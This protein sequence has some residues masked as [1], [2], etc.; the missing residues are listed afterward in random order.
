MNNPLVS[1]VVPS[2]NH[3]GFISK[4]IDSVIKQTYINWELIIVDNHSTDS[5][6]SNIKKFHD[7]RIRVVKIQNN[8]I[9][10]ISRNKGIE[11]SKGT[12]VA[13]LDS[14]DFWYPLK[15]EKS[16]SLVDKA[17]LLYH[18]MDLYKANDDI[19]LNHGLKSRKLFSPVFKDLLIRGNTL[20]NSSVIV[21]KS[22]LDEVNGLNEDKSLIAVEDYHLWLKIAL[23]TDRF[24]HISEK[25]GCYTLHEQGL[26]HRDNS[27]Q[28]R[29][30][31]AEFMSSLTERE[32]RYV[33]S[34]IRYS[35]IRKLVH[36]RFKAKYGND[37]L[38]CFFYGTFNIKIKSLFSA[39]QL[40]LRI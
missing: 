14:D 8:G 23:K 37:L 18:D 30:A 33:E 6:D 2:Y 11:E 4:M 40:F 34:F 5:T 35:R 39:I 21:R 1:I 20:I 16:L 36:F 15:L 3:G 19:V 38:Y 28:L 29:K 7:N 10:A 25:M 31:V 12:W 22:L 13:F 27:A 9:V 24:V 17:D 32:Q 26:S